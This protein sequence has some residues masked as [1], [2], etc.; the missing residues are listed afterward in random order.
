MTDVVGKSELTVIV[1][2]YNRRDLLGDCLASL[3]AQTYRGFHV[4]VVD[5]ASPGDHVRELVESYPGCETFRR[6]ENGGFARAANDGI[7]HAAT[8]FIMLLNDDMTLEPDALGRLMAEMKDAGAAMACPLVLFRDDPETIYSAGDTILEGGRP[9]SLGFREPRKDYEIDRRPFGVSAG[10]AVYSREVFAAVGLFDQRFEAYFEDADLCMRA[11]KAGFEAVCVPDAV[12]YHVGSASLEGRTAWRTR[13]CY[14]NHLLLVL[15]NYTARD[16][17][18][19]GP[20][21]LRERLHQTRMLLSACRAEAGLAAATAAWMR[22]ALSTQALA[23]QILVARVW[24]SG[25]GSGQRRSTVVPE[26]RECLIGDR[27]RESDSVY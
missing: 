10:A 27:P 21:I 3:A 17:V 9:V 14:R 18:R 26:D 16:F 8:P 22:T 13:Q 15:K 1:P 5:D 23:F 19:Q 11:R 12:A 6:A 2:T 4:L 24:G 7:R 20:A 25:S